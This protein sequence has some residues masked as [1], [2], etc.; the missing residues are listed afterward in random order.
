MIR[1][2]GSQL[3]EW[4]IIQHVTGDL[5]DELVQ[6]ILKQPKILH[7]DGG[8]DESLLDVQVPVPFRL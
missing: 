8:A 7:F 5:S 3:C 2:T 1:Q 6:R 4:T